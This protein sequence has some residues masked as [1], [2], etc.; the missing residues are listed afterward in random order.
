[1]LSRLLVL[2]WMVS[3]LQFW[4][5]TV[6]MALTWLVPGLL[7][8]ALMYEWQNYKMLDHLRTISDGH[9]R[10]IQPSVYANHQYIF[11]YVPLQI[12]FSVSLCPPNICTL[13]FVPKSPISITLFSISLLLLSKLNWAGLGVTESCLPPPSTSALQSPQCVRCGWHRMNFCYGAAQHFH[14]RCAGTLQMKH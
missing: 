10:D 11:I 3:L 8:S 12:L 1:M 2:C 7:L 14:M 4:C 6:L 13:R 5:C 9:W